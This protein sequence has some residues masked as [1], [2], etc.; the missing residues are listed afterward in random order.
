[1]VFCNL[2]KAHGQQWAG[3]CGKDLGWTFQGRGWTGT[4]E[5]STLVLLGEVRPW[6]ANVCRGV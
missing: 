2:A 5:N 6:I 3:K 4:N 1:M